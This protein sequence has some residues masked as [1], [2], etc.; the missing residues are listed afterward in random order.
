VGDDVVRERAV[1]TRKKQEKNDD[2]VKQSDPKEKI[3]CA[4]RAHIEERVRE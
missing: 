2:F 4:L 1:K 3:A